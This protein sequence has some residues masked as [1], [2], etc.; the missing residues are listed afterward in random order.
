MR[1]R[2][3]IGSALVATLV[4]LVFVDGWVGYPIISGLILLG[5]TFASQRE[6]LKM[7]AP[8][9]SSGWVLACTLLLF[10]SV[11]MGARGD[12]GH[13]EVWMIVG[14]VLVAAQII[15]LMAATGRMAR[16]PEDPERLAGWLASSSFAL[17][18]IGAPMAVLW[19]LVAGRE[20]GEG[21]ILAV[22]LVLLC[23]CADIGGYLGGTLFGRRRI[24]PRVSP[25]KSY[26]GSLTGLILTLAAA[27]GVQSV[28]PDLLEGLHSWRLAAFALVVNLFSQAGDFAESMVKRSV[29][30]KDSGNLLPGFGG[31]L[32][33]IDSLTLAIPAAVGLLELI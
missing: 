21:S 17:L 5:L 13:T 8:G 1:S 10:V 33:I 4:L 9:Q 19:S 14:G 24:M 7:L 3:S 25:K 32:D 6:L 16:G 28:A 12:D 27:W 29:G 22:V 26:E 18:W 30:V 20:G 23:K 11:A 15:L 2:L 31:A